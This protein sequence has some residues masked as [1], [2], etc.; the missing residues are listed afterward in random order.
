MIALDDDQTGTTIKPG[1]IHVGSETDI[2]DN[3]ITTS[4]FTSNSVQTGHYSSSE[5]NGN[6]P[7]VFYSSQLY[8]FKQL[9]NLYGDASKIPAGAVYTGENESTNGRTVAKLYVVKQ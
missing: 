9:I 5:L 6:G 4:T 8:T 2:S 1:L 3:G 7:L